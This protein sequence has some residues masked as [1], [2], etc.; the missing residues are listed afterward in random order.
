MTKPKNAVVLLPG[1]GRATWI[2]EARFT[3]KAETDATLGLYSMAEFTEPPGD[4]PPLHSHAVEE[5][6]FYVVDGVVVLQVGEQKLLATKGAFVLV[7]RDV[8]HTY[9]VVGDEPATLLIIISPPGFEEGFFDAGV[10]VEGPG[11]PPSRVRTLTEAEYKALD[12]KYH[13]TILGPKLGED[14]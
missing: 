2:G 13:R 8:A 9:R 12:I 5:E 7:P 3:M 10:P 1:Q 6:G 14:E 11:L 4:G